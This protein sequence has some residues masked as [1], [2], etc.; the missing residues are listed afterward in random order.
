MLIF[1]SILTDNIAHIFVVSLISYCNLSS[2]ILSPIAMISFYILSKKL[3]IK[4]KGFSDARVIS[5][6]KK[7]YVFPVHFLLRFI[8]TSW[9]KSDEWLNPFVEALVY[10]KFF[11]KK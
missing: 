6:T 10:L 11:K 3:F 9:P 7:D 2:L 1:T 8:T 4:R 5:I